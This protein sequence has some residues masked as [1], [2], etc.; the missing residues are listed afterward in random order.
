MPD[1]ELLVTTLRQYVPGDFNDGHLFSSV[2]DEDTADPDLIRTIA[3]GSLYN[4]T[5]T[6][7]VGY[8]TGGRA[9]Y[10]IESALGKID[11]TDKIVIVDS[12]TITII[13][14]YIK[15]KPHKIGYIGG[16]SVSGVFDGRPNYS[17]TNFYIYNGETE[18]YWGNSMEDSDNYNFSKT[19]T[20]I[21]NEYGEG[22]YALF[23][24]KDFIDNLIAIKLSI[25]AGQEDWE[26][27]PPEPPGQN[28]MYCD[29]L[30]CSV[31]WHLATPITG[32]YA[33]LGEHPF[34]WPY[35][36]YTLNGSITGAED[37]YC[38]GGFEIR[39]KMDHSEEWESWQNRSKVTYPESDPE[40]F[41][42][43]EPFGHGCTV[44]YR[45][46]GKTVNKVYGETI[47]FHVPIQITGAETEK[48]EK[49]QGNIRLY[50]ILTEPE[51]PE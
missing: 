27:D 25:N 1:T 24:I 16:Y 13:G 28:K 7:I 37:K 29:Q 33:Y 19:F 23:R 22:G 47:E 6:G 35:S 45:V 8:W 2:S 4:K 12:F 18:S 30:K 46:W 11:V 49:R 10:E 32:S 3:S 17:A 48:A 42:I 26:D 15:A 39:F 14:E 9:I 36:Y 44:Q 50:G 34:G 5:W 38:E 20:F 51:I 41:Q 31:A 21:N 43:N 40:T